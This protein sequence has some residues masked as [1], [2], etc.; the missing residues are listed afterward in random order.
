MARFLSILFTQTLK[1]IGK[2]AGKLVKIQQFSPLLGN[3]IN[4]S[5]DK[6]GLV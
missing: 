5:R 1:H 4:V 6:K 3:D 2:L